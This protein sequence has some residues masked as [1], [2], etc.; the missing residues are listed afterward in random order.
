[1]PWAWLTAAVAAN[2]AVWL[3]TWLFVDRRRGRNRLM[4]WLVLSFVTSLIPL[5]V[6]LSDKPLRFA[7]SL[8]TI[9]TLVK[10]G[11]IFLTPGTISL[12]SLTRCVAYF[13][14]GF[15]HVLRLP[16]PLVARS[17]DIRWITWTLPTAL[18]TIAMTNCVFRADWSRHSVVSEHL[19]KVPVL[20]VAVVLTTNVL[21]SFW[22]LAGRHGFVPMQNILGARSPAEF[23]QRWNVPTAQFLFHDVYLP[24]GGRRHPI[25]ATFLVFVISGLIHEYVI[26]IAAGRVTGLQ[27][28]FFLIQGIAAV[29]CS[30]GPRPKQAPR[31]A[32][33]LT[34]TFNLATS[35]LFFASLNTVLPFYQQ[36]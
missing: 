27:L 16:P 1:M 23:W 26:G 6:P 21:S 30:C 12:F 8:V 9:T 28:L 31:V 35:A 7:A 33:I 13:T 17:R 2:V 29:V 20:V 5:L 34:L 3:V 11:D 32:T 15:W 14:N 22:R 4:F 10:L 24:L 25:R 36:R 18:M 19:A